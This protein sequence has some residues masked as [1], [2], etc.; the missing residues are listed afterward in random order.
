MRMPLNFGLSPAGPATR[1]Q[2]QSMGFKARTA[3]ATQRM[4]QEGGPVVLAASRMVELMEVAASRLM[5]QY[6]AE[7]QMSVGIETND[8]H[9]AT[10][11]V[12]GVVRAVATYTG[13]A[14]RVHRFTITVFDESGLIGSGDHTRIV[15]SEYTPRARKRPPTVRPAPLRVL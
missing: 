15:A 9:R 10:S 8:T 3:E 7:G 5:Q 1:N 11:P 13:F 12:R 4:S 14:G 6:L 2:E